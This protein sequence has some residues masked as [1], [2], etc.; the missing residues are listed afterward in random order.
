M[1]TYTIYADLLFLVN[2]ILDIVLLYAVS[3]FGAF[4]TSRKRLFL[5]ALAGAAYGVLLV[6][7]ALSFLGNFFCKLLASFFVVRV[8]FPHL[9]WKKYLAA[10]V[11]FYL[12]SFAMAGAV[13]G[14]TAL[15]EGMGFPGS[16]FTFTAFTLIF[17]LIVCLLLS[18]W[19]SDYVKKNFRRNSYAEMIDITFNGKSAKVNALIDTGNELVDPIS[20]RPVIVAEFD[21][22]REIL[23]FSLQDAFMRHGRGDA[24]KILAELI[25][26]PVAR[27]LR[28]V[29]FSSIG[30]NNGLLLGFKPDEIVVPG[31]N[32]CRIDNT[33]ICLYWGKIHTQDDC[34]CIINPAIF[35]LI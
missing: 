5:A 31:R 21:A 32:H 30:K 14:G 26:K 33:I 28:L 34:R 4:S 19:G 20:K 3:R 23:P 17:A 25:E 35:D 8:A 12:I 13:M 7:P 15:L 27:S 11:Y 9:T 16:G 2:F 18:K 10:V 6:F 29:P 24:A 22:V 1:T